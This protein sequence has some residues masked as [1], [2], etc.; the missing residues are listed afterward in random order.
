MRAAAPLLAA[1]ALWLPAVRSQELEARVTEALH[2]ARQPLLDHLQQATAGS[3]GGLLALLC[4]AAQHDG[5]PEDDPVFAA[6]L[7]RLLRAELHQTYDLSLRLLVLEGSTA[8]RDR[9]KIARQDCERL[10]QHRSGGAFGYSR[11]SGNWDLSN[12]QYAALGLRA[13]QAIGVSIER[14]VWTA[15]ADDVLAAQHAPGGFGYGPQRGSAL[16]ATPSMTVAGIAVLAICRQGLARPGHVL[17]ELDRRIG[18][19]WQ[20]MDRHGSAVGDPSTRWN[21][22]FHYGLERAAILCDVATVGGAD[23]YRRGAEMLVQNQRQGGGWTSHT[24]TGPGAELGG[25]RGAPVPTA[26]AVLFLR[27]KFQKIPGPV[28]PARTL[29]LDQ[30]T[31]QA[32]T[33]EIQQCANGLLQRGKG[34]LPEVLAALRHDLAPRRHAALH[35]LRELAGQDFGI[36]A[37]KPPEQNTEALRR[38]ELWYLK[39]R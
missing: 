33:A 15:L 37:D 25:G 6:A 34:A 26:F 30:L 10:L 14:K 12:T 1:A 13:A 28:T 16:D 39:N 27:R 9:L 32:T 5:V 19:A 35:A 36:V 24:D 38:A 23:W 8:A 29:T 3:Q 18:K 31:E 17:P 20:W 11:G 22:Y 7:R 2:R 21:L 4:L